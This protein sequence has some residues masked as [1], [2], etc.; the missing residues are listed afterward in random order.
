MFVYTI[1]SERRLV[2]VVPRLRCDE[3]VANLI[4]SIFLLGLCIVLII[5]T[6]TGII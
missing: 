5:L 4:D 1:K 6:V 2:L 3:V